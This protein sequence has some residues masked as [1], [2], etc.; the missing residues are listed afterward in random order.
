M[1]LMS[2]ISQKRS[3]FANR[4]RSRFSML[5]STHLTTVFRGT[6]DHENLSEV[7]ILKH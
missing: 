6:Y 2:R 3:S 7:Y 4:A 1:C 5:K